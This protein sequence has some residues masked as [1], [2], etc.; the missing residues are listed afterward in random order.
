MAL[1]AQAQFVNR[2]PID[3]IGCGL[4]HIVLKSV[5]K[6]F[7]DKARYRLVYTEAGATHATPYIPP[8]PYPF[9]RSTFIG[10][11]GVGGWVKGG[12]RGVGA[13]NLP[14]SLA[15]RLQAGAH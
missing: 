7:L 11:W 2:N 9:F 15:F 10:V 13:R 6:V 3:F 12:G 4:V 5:C 8:P 1:P 14:A